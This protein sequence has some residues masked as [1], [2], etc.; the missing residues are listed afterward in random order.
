M[1]LRFLGTG[2]SFG[3]PVI[4]CSCATCTSAD[5]RDRRLRHGAIIEDGGRR[6]LIDAPPELRLQLLDARVESVD[7]VWIT[8]CHADHVHGIDDLRA[9]TVRPSRTLDM[10]APPDCAET[11]RSR[12]DYIFDEDQR[13]EAGTSKPEL[14]LNDLPLDRDIDIAGFTIT[15]IPVRHGRSVPLGLRCGSLG[16]ITDAK[17]IPPES[18]ERLAGVRVLVLNAL[19]HGD[20]HPTHLN[21]EEAI[22]LARTI[23]AERTLLTHL[24]HRVRHAAL[25]AALPAG[26]EP[27]YDGLVID[28]DS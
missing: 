18:L 22:E 17:T 10:W 20:P 1:R 27:A 9:F 16:Y 26:I 19:W 24:T 15:P 5:P 2:T 21:V 12:F 25:A 8:H 7:A 11:M 4:G 3:I 6:L 28:I 14:T 13:P 23:G